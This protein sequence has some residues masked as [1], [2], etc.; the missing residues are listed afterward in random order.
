M[1][2]F[3]TPWN[4][5]EFHRVLGR[6]RSGNWGC[7]CG[8]VLET[9]NMAR[10]ATVPT[11]SSTF[12]HSSLWTKSAP[13]THSSWYMTCSMNSSYIWRLFINMKSSGKNDGRHMR[14]LFKSLTTKYCSLITVCKREI[15]GK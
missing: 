12:F 15:S 6:D 10:S 5:M 4:K 14:F 7:L 8:F 2:D 11:A 13:S 9:Y 1:D 3:P